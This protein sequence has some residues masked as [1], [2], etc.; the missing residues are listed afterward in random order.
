MRI[1]AVDRAKNGSFEGVK[2]SIGN[3]IIQVFSLLL[4]ASCHYR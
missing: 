1:N 2:W 3:I 4:S